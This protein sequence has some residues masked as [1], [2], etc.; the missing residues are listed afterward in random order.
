MVSGTPELKIQR[1][2]N[3]ISPELIG[4]YTLAAGTVTINQT[5]NTNTLQEADYY[6]LKLTGSASYDMSDVDLISKTFTVSGS[7]I[8][9]NTA[10]TDLT[11]TDSLIYSTSAV[12]TLTGDLNAAAIKLTGGTL[13]D[14]GNTITVTSKDWNNS[15]GTF[16]ANGVTKFSGS[17]A[18][19]ISGSTSTTFNDLTIAN[20]SGITLNVA[21][22]VKGFLRLTS[23]LVNTTSTNLL[24]LTSTASTTI[25]SATSYVNG[26]LACV[27]AN[28][29][30]S[31]LTFPIG[32]G[33]AWRPAIVTPTHSTATSYTYTGELLSS[34]A[35]ALNLTLPGTIKNVSSV[36]YWDISRSAGSTD[37]TSASVE[38]YY[39]NTN[40]SD[41]FVTDHANLTIGRASTGATAW[42]DIGG[43]ASANSAGTITASGITSFSKFTLAN[44]S[45]G[46]N[47]L[48]VELVSF[49]A[50][51]NESSV[52]LKWSTASEKNN[53]YFTI[54]RTK[55]G[56]EYQELARV[57]G[58]GNSTTIL[59]YSRFDDAPYTGASY[60][61]LKQTDFD[62]KTTYSKLQKVNFNETAYDGASQLELYPNPNEGEVINLNFEAAEDQQILIEMHDLS[63]KNVY[64]LSIMAEKGANKHTIYMATKLASG[65]YIISTSTAH[66]KHLYTTK[67]TV[68]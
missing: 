27:M 13:A 37:L 66:G 39:S 63:G 5:A 52:E 12:S 30:T 48:P 7:S 21:A 61:R 29:G 3:T 2:N 35:R 67:F 4:T 23:G 57:Q 62:G 17:S 55:D 49:T 34:S 1:S 9:K 38:F 20:S 50:T 18:Q 15:G 40:G 60:Y 31:T 42:T 19:T 32:K 25:G 16:T 65:T 51:P 6:N 68:E 56:F 59:N 28:S 10:N 33:G 24:T 26:P 43:T 8:W 14:G 47:P 46:I 45:A 53:D 44:K 54:E 22:S 11:I 64:N 58:A 41:D 36:R